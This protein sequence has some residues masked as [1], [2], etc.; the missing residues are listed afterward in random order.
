MGIIDCS[1]FVEE[2]FT[3]SPRAAREWASF[4]ALDLMPSDKLR[5]RVAWEAARLMYSR[6]ES[7]YFRAKLK[8][9]RRIAGSD[10]KPSDLPSNRE[11]RDEV[12]V[13]ARMHEGDRRDDNLR[14]NADRSAAIDA[15]PLEISP[16]GLS[17]ARSPGMCGAGRTSICI[18]SPTAW[19]RWPP[20]WKSTEFPTKSSENSSASRGKSGSTRTYTFATGSSSS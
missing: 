11:I 20:P 14:A 6:E 1:L 12:Q 17:A 15:D 5:R 18:C 2:T 4:R 19:K 10:F 8:A 9:A 3:K 16:P 7:E 13:M